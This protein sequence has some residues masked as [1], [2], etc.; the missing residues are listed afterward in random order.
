MRVAGSHEKTGDAVVDDVE[1]AAD[2]TAQV[3]TT[4]GDVSAGRLLC[5]EELS[6]TSIYW[7]D[8]RLNILSQATH[9][10]GDHARLV[11]A[12]G[13]REPGSIA[14]G[15]I[16][17]LP[18]EAERIFRLLKMLHPDRDMHSAYVGLQSDD[19]LVHDNAVE[20]LEA[21]L[22]PQLRA[23]IVPLFDRNVSVPEKARIAARMFHAPLTAG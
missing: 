23:Q 6:E 19:P 9:T 16:D 20:F 21:V 7:T 14:Q 13:E 11:D 22:S 12:T 5:T 18:R 4:I 8:D 10:K 17:G 3:A 15:L 1:Q 2:G